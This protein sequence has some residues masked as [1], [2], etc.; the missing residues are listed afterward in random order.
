MISGNPP[1]TTLDWF[2]ALI[3][4]FPEGIVVQVPSGQIIEAN[5]AAADIL[6]LTMNQLLGKDSMDPGWRA[7]QEDG[8]HYPGQDHP[9]MVAMRTGEVQ[10]KKIMGVMKP[11]G[12]RRWILIQAIPLKDEATQEV[13]QT[14]TTFQD[15]TEQRELLRE[16]SDQRNFLNSV[17]NYSPS[18]IYAKDLEG[19]YLL[20]NSE[21]ER[22]FGLSREQI[23]GKTDYDLF[24]KQIA[25]QFRNNDREIAFTQKATQSEEVAPHLDGIHHYLSAK[26][27]IFDQKG[28]VVATAGISTDITEKKRLQSE[29]ALAHERLQIAMRAV[30]FGI[31]DWDV[32]NNILVWDDYLYEVFGIRKEDFGGAYEAFE[33]VLIPEERPRISKELEETFARQ[34]DFES[35]F[36]IKRSDGA[37]RTIRAKSRGF[38]DSEGKVLRHVGVNWDVTE[39][40]EQEMRLFQS[41]KM[42]SLGE[43]SAGIAHEINNPLTVIRGRA[44]QIKMLLESEPESAD[45]AI[46]YVDQ[47][48]STVDR[49]AKIIQSLRAFAREGST[50]NFEEV[51]IAQVVSDTLSFCKSR[52]AHHEVEIHLPEI[53]DS[54]KVRGRGVQ[55]GQVLLNLLNNAFDA[56]SANTEKWVRLDVKDLGER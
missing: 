16:A 47:I 12:L 32:K 6:G 25:D 44:T 52:F 10:R 28:Q 3:R 35:E 23:I 37:L 38:Y 8:A 11:N 51:S 55:L 40:R 31:W 29:L 19:R 36:R 33:N 30:R 26:F 43:I 22:I 42:S 24:S 14:V 17:V 1:P 56:A 48:T 54:L 21:Y 4:D 39:Q 5:Q 50:D 49:I 41:S 18:V 20:A 46:K 15:V 9:A 27:P 53:S 2:Q 45:K 7:I 13:I 34:G